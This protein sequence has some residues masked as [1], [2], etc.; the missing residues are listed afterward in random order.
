VEDLKQTFL[1]I[2]EKEYDEFKSDM[3]RKTKE[4]IF[5]DY[6]IINFYS[7]IYEFLEN[8][9]LSGRQYEILIKESEDGLL[10]SMWGEY[11]RC[12]YASIGNYEDM[13]DFI[14]RFVNYSEENQ[15][16]M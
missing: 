11:L 8:S 12:D 7:E 16:A 10:D 9:E 2:I 4:E 5:D 6:G 13:E 14:S 1:P 3:L 15:E